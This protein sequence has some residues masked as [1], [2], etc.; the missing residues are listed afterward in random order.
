MVLYCIDLE[1]CQGILQ[2]NKEASMVKMGLMRSDGM[3]GG[4]RIG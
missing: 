4:V 2:G 1:E 3:A